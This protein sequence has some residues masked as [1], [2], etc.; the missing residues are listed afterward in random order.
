MVDQNHYLDENNIKTYMSEINGLV[1]DKSHGFTRTH[2]FT[3]GMDTGMG[4]GSKGDYD[5][6]TKHKKDDS[7]PNWYKMLSTNKKG[8]Y[9]GI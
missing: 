5:M 9:T 3:G 7:G 6:N 2:G 4:G 1:K 8:K